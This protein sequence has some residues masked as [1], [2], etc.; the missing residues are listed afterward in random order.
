MD[1]NQEG[2]SA[3][4]PLDHSEAV[5]LLRLLHDRSVRVRT[6]AIRALVLLPMSLALRREV[7]HY[8]EALLTAVTSGKSDS[9]TPPINPIDAIEVAIYFP[10]E[11]VCECLRMIAQGPQQEFHQ[12]AEKALAAMGA[13]RLVLGSN[14]HSVVPPSP[15]TTQSASLAHHTSLSPEKLRRTFQEA[16]DVSGRFYS[17]LTLASLDEPEYIESVFRELEHGPLNFSLI[18]YVRE[19]ISDEF[20]PTAVKRFR[21]IADDRSRRGDVRQIAFFLSQRSRVTAPDSRVPDISVPPECA[22]LRD[23][24]EALVDSFLEDRAWFFEPDGDD[25][26]ALRYIDQRWASERITS[27]FLR[28]LPALQFWDGVEAGNKVVRLVASFGPAFVPDIPALFEV[29]LRMHKRLLPARAEW[30]RTKDDDVI[31]AKTGYLAWSWQL[32]WTVSRAGIRQVLA[33][34]TPSLSSPDVNERLAAAQ[35]IEDATRYTPVTHPPQ[36]GGGTGPPDVDLLT[37]TDQSEEAARISPE[38]AIKIPPDERWNL[39]R[40]YAVWFGT[41]RAPV[42]A[43]DTG[44]GFSNNRDPHGTVR[45]GTCLV[46]IPRAHNDGSTGTPFW[47]RW[48]KLKFTDDH[49]KLE[50]IRPFISADDFLA[51]LREEM[52]SHEQEDERIV[53]VYLH[54]YNTSFEQAALRAAQIGFDLKVD[55]TAFYSWPSKAAVKGYAADIARVEASERQIAGFL[56]AVATGSGAHRVHVIA[57]S[58]G[59]RGFARAVSRITHAAATSGV[60]FGQIILAAP[61]MDVDL[62]KDLAIAYPKISQRTTMYVSAKDKALSMSSWLQDSDRAGFTPPVTVVKGIDTVEVTSIDLTLLGHG[63][64]AAAGPVLD[65]MKAL[66]DAGKPP[67][68]R[69]RIEGRVQ[70]KKKFWGIRA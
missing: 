5:P 44:K 15:A 55:T 52:V 22:D 17:A 47:K 34:L 49:L 7:G 60:R 23:H 9:T 14:R 59:N 53:L 48:L 51:A 36:F 21:R 67:D 28:L 35:L 12:P 27:L 25:K 41:N 40:L 61:D 58:M 24:A 63:Y 29:Y 20:R 1:D 65:D 46:Y 26:E 2:R 62:F 66:I 11:R 38:A 43:S 57:H 54:G 19:D 13:R 64:F 69:R 45:Y 10:T 6:A 33:D 42:D 56:T 4:D 68:K 39:P 16:A 3:I 32:A 37:Y 18:R 50:M 70:G 30:Y 8:I 31:F